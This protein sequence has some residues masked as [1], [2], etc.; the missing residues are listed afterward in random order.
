M[1]A[2]LSKKDLIMTKSQMIKF[3]SG[4]LEGLVTLGTKI[5]MTYIYIDKRHI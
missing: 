2:H 4:R 3:C 5:Q 1:T